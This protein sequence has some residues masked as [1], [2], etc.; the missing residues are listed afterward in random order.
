[1]PGF[2]MSTLDRQNK[3]T[4]MSI[5]V[6]SGATDPQL[7][8]VTDAMDV[9]IL[10]SPLRA[11]KTTPQVIDA[12]D[13]TPPTNKDANRGNKWLFRFQDALTG[14]IYNHEL[15]TADN[16]VLSTASDDFID[17]TAGDGLSLKSA[18]DVV[19]ESP[20]GNSGVLLSVQQVTRTD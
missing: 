5:Q 3:P 19:Y 10:G 9:V 14:K 4:S 20:A 11:V 2:K 1:M 8:A 18:L 12:G 17:L 16:N 13:A 15:G 6:L 7:Q